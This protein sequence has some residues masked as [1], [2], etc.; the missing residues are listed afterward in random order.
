MTSKKRQNQTFS[1]DISAENVVTIMKECRDSHTGLYPLQ[2]KAAILLASGESI[3]AVAERLEITRSTIYTWLGQI[4]F[5]CYY[6]QQC[7]DYKERLRA[8]IFSLADE[9]ITAIRD[10]LHSSNEAVKLKAAMW[11]SERIDLSEVGG[12]NLRAR[13]KSYYT[14]TPGYLDDGIFDEAGYNEELKRLNLD[15]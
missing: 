12:T 1:G 8:G 3:T 10:C 11:L 9:A 4:P 14:E 6:N 5:S 2:E 15:E 7:K 13:L